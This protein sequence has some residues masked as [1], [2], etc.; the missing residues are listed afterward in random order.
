MNEA[1]KKILERNL[2]RNLVEPIPSKDE[3]EKVFQ[4]ALRAPDHA[5]LRPFKLH[6]DKGEMAPKNF[7]I[8][9]L[10]LLKKTLMI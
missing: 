6:S 1:L 3:M 5:W 7:Q 9:L 8:Y 2:H 4:A 10:I